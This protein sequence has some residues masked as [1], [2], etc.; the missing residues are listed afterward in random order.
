MKNL[1]KIVSIIGLIVITQTAYILVDNSSSA[2]ASTLYAIGNPGPGGGIVF[3]VTDG[4]LHGLEAAVVDQEST[5]WGCSGTTISG[6][7]ATVVGTGEQNTADII[8]GCNETTA[9]SVASAYG[10]GWHLPS[11]NELNLLYAQKVA[12]VVGG[13]ASSSYWSSS[14]TNSSNAWYQN[15][16]YGNQH[17]YDKNTTLRVRAVRAF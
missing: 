10:P 5:Q 11:K 15:F 17:Y 2:A 3:H 13:F 9:V 4:G 6:A 16:Y 1:L 8:A 14:Q 7:N 12:G